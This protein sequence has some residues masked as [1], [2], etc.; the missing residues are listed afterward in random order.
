MVIRV[1]QSNCR[2]SPD[3]TTTLLR[4]A[5]GN[6][7]V[8]L[9]QEFWASPKDNNGLWKTVNDANFHFV[10][11]RN[12]TDRNAHP[13]TM[14]AVSK[15]IRS[16]IEVTERDM[17]AIWVGEPGE[18]ILI[19]NVYNPNP[20]PQ[21]LGPLRSRR[22]ANL[23]AKYTRWVIAGDFNAHHPEWSGRHRN[24]LGFFG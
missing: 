15:N 10:F 9:A 7:E 22:A 20:D 12:C 8:V 24:H 2:K 3:C 19:V 21:N 18:E 16:R 1:I 4:Q 5:L 17:V 23:L 13:R 6:A 11:D 14:T